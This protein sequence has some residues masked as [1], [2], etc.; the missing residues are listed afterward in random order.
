LWWLGSFVLYSIVLGNASG[1]SGAELTG[2]CSHEDA[3]AEELCER[4]RDAGGGGQ[5]HG[6]AAD[7][8]QDRGRGHRLWPFAGRWLGPG[9]GVL[10]VNGFSFRE[11]TASCCRSA[12][13]CSSVTANGV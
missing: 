5:D 4:R 12:F 8:R 11:V 10:L 13:G 2:D 3:G 1:E 9:A 7:H 6:D